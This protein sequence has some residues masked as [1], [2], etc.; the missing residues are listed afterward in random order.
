M[1]T[2]IHAEVPDAL[3]KE[4]QRYV[5]RGW[6]EDMQGLIAES[7][8]RF[9]ESHQESITEQFIQEDLTWGLHGED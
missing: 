5:E 7:L 1:P 3:W 6:A 9:L 4:A 2:I 8:R